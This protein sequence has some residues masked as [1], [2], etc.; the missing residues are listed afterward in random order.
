MEVRDGGITLGAATQ[1][2][3]GRSGAQEGAVD[4][5]WVPIAEGPRR[6]RIFATVINGE[7]SDLDNAIDVA[8]NVRTEALPILFHEAEASWL[9]TLYVARS[10]T[11]AGLRWR[12]ARDW[13]RQYLVT[14]GAARGVTDAVLRGVESR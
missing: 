10:R 6:L 5:A 8:A 7:R 2:W 4:V 13:H 3:D 11:M 1:T 12:A 9:G 14:R